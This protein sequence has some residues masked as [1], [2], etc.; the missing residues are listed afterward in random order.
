MAWPKKKTKQKKQLINNLFN[1]IYENWNPVVS[2][3][4]SLITIDRQVLFFFLFIICVSFIVIS[5]HT[6]FPNCDK[7]NG[8]IEVRKISLCVCELSHVRL[9]ATL[10][11]VA[12]QDLLS[13]EFSRQEYWSGLPL[14]SPGDLP[15]PSIKLVS[16]VSPAVRHIL[17]HC[18]AS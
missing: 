9:F 8:V 2:T 15:D 10:W 18:A 1:Q 12:H 3:A 4:I 11:N 14:P 17:Y 5:F 7:A 16:L 6:W 13:M